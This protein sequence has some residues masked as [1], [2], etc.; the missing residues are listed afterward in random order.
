MTNLTDQVAQKARE[1]HQIDIDGEQHQFDRHQD[2]DDVFPVQEDTENPDGEQDRGNG[3][4]MSKSDNHLRFPP[5]ARRLLARPS[6]RVC[7]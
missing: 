1:S 3:Q 4:V 5:P 6:L 7:G 2:D